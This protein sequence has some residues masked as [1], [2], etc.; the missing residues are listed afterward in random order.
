MLYSSANVS[1]SKS[2]AN[3]QSDKQILRLRHLGR[4]I[5]SKP[6]PDIAID[7]YNLDTNRQ[8]V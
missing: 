8:V 6:L 4:I 2:M 5:L 3:R 7:E 1:V